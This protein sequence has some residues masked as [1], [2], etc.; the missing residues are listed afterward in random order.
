MKN[1]PFLHFLYDTTKFFVKVLGCVAA[2]NAVFSGIHKINV[3]KSKRTGNYYD[4]KHG[5]IFFTVKGSGSPVLL[6]HGLSSGNCGNDLKDAEI[7]LSKYHEVYTIDLLGYG[8]SDKPWITYTNYL[9]VTLIRDF[10]S[11]VIGEETDICAFRNSCLFVMQANK[12]CGDLI[13][14][15]TLVDPSRKETITI[16]R[17]TALR[18][19]N[20]ICFPIVGTLIY[21]LYS[22]ACKKSLDPLSR[23]VFMSRVA[24]YLTSDITGYDYLMTDNVTIAD[25]SD[26]AAF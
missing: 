17:S 10:I 14:D 24:G 11:D 22:L 4:W 3:K 18:M 6:I 23:H 12:V 21:N 9:Y 16:P 1:H 19:K 7:R 5:K 2:V 13:G 20:I 25:T 26:M 8:L 15:I